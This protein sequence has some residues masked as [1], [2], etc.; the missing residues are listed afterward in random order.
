MRRALSVL[1][2]LLGGW[3]L[4][5]EVAAAFLDAMP[6]LGDSALFIGVFGGLAL[7]ALVLGA[8]ASPGPRKR[9]LGVTILIAAGSALF[10]AIAAVVMFLDPGFTQFLPEMPK[11]ALAPAVGAVN[12]VIVAA[13]GGLLYRRG[14]RPEAR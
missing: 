4:M 13:I 6:G 3:M 10:C 12:L 14:G 9:E 5:T 2:F 11:I 8:W 7:V 1:L